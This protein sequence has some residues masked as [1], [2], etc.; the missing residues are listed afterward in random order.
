MSHF[1]NPNTY[2]RKYS[3]V[4][5][6]SIK[7]MNNSLIIKKNKEQYIYDIDDNKY[8]DFYLQNGEIFSGYTPSRLNHFQKNALSAGLNIPNGYNKF[9]YKAQKYWQKI[10][11]ISQIYFYSSFLN[12]ILA[13]I[14][15]LPQKIVIGYNSQYIKQLL[16]PISKIIS[17][18]DINKTNIYVDILLFEE[19]NDELQYFDNNSIHSSIKIQI[20]SRF[21]FRGLQKSKINFSHD[22]SHI[23]ISTPFGGKEICLL[24]GS[25]KLIQE[26][27]NFED[28]ILFLEGAKYFTIL[29]KQQLIEFKHSHF[30]SYYGFAQCTKF[31]DSNF[32]RKRGIYI[33]GNILF[34]SPLH[35]QHNFKRLYK[36]LDT[37]FN[38][39]S[40]DIPV[41]K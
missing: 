14:N 25:H 8:I 19:L 35:T 17:C 31:L 15:S 2:S 18:I 24:A 26:Y 21:L 23:V 16:L 37:Y 5:L 13:I 4:H 11:N 7:N 20:H 12:C 30:I 9:I 33:Q 1:P 32:F 39:N 34:F 29:A 28:G 38:Q 6:S 22:I 10:L 27:I 36:I 41:Q 3:D 40:N